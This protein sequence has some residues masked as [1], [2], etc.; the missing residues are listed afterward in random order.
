MINSDTPDILKDIVELKRARVEE[1]KK[2]LSMR[3][4]EITVEDGQGE[5]D[6]S[7]DIKDVEFRMKNPL[8]RA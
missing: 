4:M 3:D 7:I 6:S 2:F 1:R 5:A 8:S